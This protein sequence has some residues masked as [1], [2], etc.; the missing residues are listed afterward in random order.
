LH[1]FGDSGQNFVRPG[2]ADFAARHRIAWLSPDGAE[3]SAGQRFWNAGTS[4]C[5]FDEIPVDHVGALRELLETAIRGGNIDEERVFVLGFSNGGFM[6]H[7]LA[8]ELDGLVKAVVSIAGAGPV[9]AATCRRTAPL[10]VLEIHGDA[11]QVVS[12][13]GGTVFRHGRYRQHLSA[14]RTVTDWAARLGCAP[15]PEPVRELDFERQLPGAETRAERFEGC[16]GAVELWTVHGGRHAI[17]FRPPSQAS[18]WAFL[19]PG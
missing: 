15:D 11:D 1:G 9:D 8:C 3:D 7:R 12:Y 19:N 6:A 16:R 4:C 14:R 10:R 2:W 5:N 18:I 17:G 13:Q